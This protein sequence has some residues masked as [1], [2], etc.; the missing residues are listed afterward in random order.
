VTTKKALRKKPV[1][2]ARMNTL[3]TKSRKPLRRSRRASREAKTGALIQKKT[4][5]IARCMMMA[6]KQSFP[7]II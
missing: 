5:S 2:R 3:K 7:Q 1:K 6:M 4:Y